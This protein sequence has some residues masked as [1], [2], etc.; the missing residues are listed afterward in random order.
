MKCGR[1]F[2]NERRKKRVREKLW[3]KYVWGKQTLKQ[4]SRQESK[5]IPWIRKELSNAPL[6][7]AFV[8]PQPTVIIADT[9]FFGRHYGVT[10]L[11]SQELKKNLWWDEVESERQASYH[12]GRKILESQGWSFKAA[13]VDGRR[14]LATV[15]ADIAVQICQFHQVKLVRKHLSR[16]PGTKAAREL[17]DIAYTLKHSNEHTF[18]IRLERWERKWKEHIEEKKFVEGIKREKFVNEKTRKAYKSLERNLP[19]LFTYQK[20]PELNIPKTTNTMEG[21]FSQLK[22]KLRNHRGM[23]KEMRFKMISE[24]LKGEN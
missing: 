6:K 19:Y 2:Q 9:T 14:G 17:L 22:E 13:V 12:Y 10:L 16:R 7:P 20:Y 15:F 11:R 8:T 4:L 21:S 23:T 3:K 1:V 5:S 18:T 24:V